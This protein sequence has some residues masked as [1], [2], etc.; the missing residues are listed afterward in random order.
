MNNKSTI[1]DF[2]NECKVEILSALEDLGGIEVLKEG[3]KTITIWSPDD[4]E[5]E[6]E[7]KVTLRKR[8]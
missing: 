2:I 7:V 3:D 8:L 5:L 4:P 1:R 6:I